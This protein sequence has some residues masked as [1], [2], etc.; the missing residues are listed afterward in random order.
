LDGLQSG[1]CSGIG[2]CIGTR[3]ISVLFVAPFAFSAPR[4]LL[5]SNAAALD[6][7]SIPTNEIWYDVRVRLHGSL[8]IT[9]SFLA[10][11]AIGLGAVV[12]IVS[13]DAGSTILANY[14]RLRKLVGLFVGRTITGFFEIS[15]LQA[16]RA[17]HLP[18]WQPVAEVVNGIRT[19]IWRQIFFPARIKT[20]HGY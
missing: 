19:T 12:N 4:S 1:G 7:L 17:A 13:A 15:D 16:I 10:H 20:C 11:L 8:I 14:A 5:E 2:S 6:E 3:I 9:L 18:E